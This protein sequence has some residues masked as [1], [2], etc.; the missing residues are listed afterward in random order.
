MV[1]LATLAHGQVSLVLTGCADFAGL[2]P[3]VMRSILFLSVPIYNPFGTN[4]QDC[5]GFQPWCSS[6]G[7]MILCHSE[8]IQVHLWMYGC[9]AGCWLWQ[10]E[11]DI[12]SALGGWKRCNR[13]TRAQ[14]PAKSV[15]VAMHGHLWCVHFW[16]IWI[17]LWD[18]KNVCNAGYT[19]KVWRKALNRLFELLMALL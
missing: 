8:C 2:A 19:N 4:I 6:S 7:R 1:C 16:V 3:W 17:L 10:S 11:S 13:L 12:W 15:K 9:D 5:L 14:N 18:S